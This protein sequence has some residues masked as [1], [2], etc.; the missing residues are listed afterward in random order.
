MLVGHNLL[1]CECQQLYL[2][3][4]AACLQ[5]LLK[6]NIATQKTGNLNYALLALQLVES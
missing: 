1:A 3:P 2:P 4:V 5:D 6:T